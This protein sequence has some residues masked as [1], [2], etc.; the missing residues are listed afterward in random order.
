[1]QPNAQTKADG[2]GGV[3]FEFPAGSKRP[4]PEPAQPSTRLDLL[5]HLPEG[6][7][8][9]YVDDVALMCNIHQSTG[10]LIALGIVSA[11]A[12][13]VFGV[14]YQNGDALPVGEY[15]ICGGL[16]G[17]A[18]SRMLKTF[19]WP[20]FQAHKEAVKDY[21]RREA[22][23]K[24][25]PANEGQKF[26]EPY[27][28]RIFITDSTVEALEPIL[29][30]SG[31]YFA[32]ASAEQA[33]INTLTGAS[34]GGEGR[35]NNND[36]PLKGFNAEYHASSRSTRDS[37][38]G[39]VIGSITCFAQPAAIETIL[40]KSE[41]SGMAERFLLAEEP[42][43]QGTRDHTRQHYPQAYSQNV[44]NR[45]VGELAKRALEQPQD[46]EDLPAYRISSSD[47]HKI[48]LFRNELEPHLADGG[49]YSTATMR[50]VASKVDMHIMK[51]AA[52]LACLYEHPTGEIPSQFID[53]A[54]SIMKDMLDNTLSLLFKIGV[55]GFNAEEHQIIDYLG[56]R[57]GATRRQVQEAKAK[58]KP[59][60]ESQSPYK[61]ISGTIDRLIQKG[62][63]VEA[64]EIG[65][66]GT[67]RRLLYLAA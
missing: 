30:K 28:S 39:L 48:Y 36:L 58:V 49:K 1:M 40:A 3:V 29:A 22:E 8:K 17:D 27:P 4:E 38:T 32:L 41:G 55:I 65:H 31:G 11:V 34:Y 24:E 15:V 25:D 19:Q 23:F 13:R 2:L 44:Y 59:F 16:P 62:V 60:R 46:F 26:K 37:Y 61:A 56:N 12:C 21:R 18:K 47:W 53:A 10:L 35:K 43:Q 20:V 33:V 66:D 9:Q 57:K 5:K 6:S 50:G 14:Q 45:I 52:L 54:I 7:F 64:L 63:V 67:E 42:T 51:L